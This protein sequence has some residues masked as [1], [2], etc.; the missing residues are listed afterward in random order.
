MVIPNKKADCLWCGSHLV[1]Y[2][3]EPWQTCVQRSDEHIIPANVFGRV[4]TFDL[5]V[6]CN[7]DFGEACDH[8]FIRDQRVIAA[9]QKAG[10]KLTDLRKTFTGMQKMDTGGQTKMRYSNG[11]FQ[12]EPQL[13]P[14][15]NLIAPTEKWASLRKQIL[16][17]LIA[18][19]LRKRLQLSKIEIEQEV[20]LLLGSVDAAPGEVHWNATIG[21]G[22][23]PAVS[24]GN[25]VGFE[26]YF[27]W[28]TEWSLA[29]IVYELSLLTWP[30]EYQD[31]YREAINLFREFL[32][33]REHDMGSKT[34]KGI[35]SFVE[36]NATP[37]KEHTVD[38]VMTP[39]SLEW[40]LNFFGT[41]HWQWNASANP[42]N[43]PPGLGWSLKIVN[44]TVGDDASVTCQRL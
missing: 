41:A 27:P 10:F 11:R 18:K 36:T 4:R 21:E 30:A 7:S 14:Q 12:S 33:R 32:L 29:K 22:F 38:C 20:D 13:N 1:N 3:P 35:F 8:A 42:I 39:N 16:G 31:Y 37:S 5:C 17:S 2:K 15:F 26:E 25:V 23:R 19:V 6:G 34:G 44:P 43:A 40:R 9:A 24:S 28:E